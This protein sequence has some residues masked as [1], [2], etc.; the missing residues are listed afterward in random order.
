MEDKLIVE[1]V[2]F[3]SGL[4]LR[5][6][7][8]LTK[9]TEG[10]LLNMYDWELGLGEGIRYLVLNV[11]EVP[12]MN[13]AGIAMLI[14]I[15]RAGK[16]GGYQ[17]FACGLTAHYQKLFHMVGLTDYIIIYPDEYSVLKRLE[18]ES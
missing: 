8:D 15:S 4:L 12:Y 14:R 18:D 13:S 5:L 2:A 10:I 3:P 6:A 1:E 9:T 16:K 7:G 11:S 17:T